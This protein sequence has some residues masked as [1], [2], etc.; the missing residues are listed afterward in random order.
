MTMKLDHVSYALDGSYKSSDQERV[1]D[2]IMPA[3]E[4]AKIPELIADPVAIIQDRQLWQKKAT[5][6]S[7]DVIIAMEINGKKTLVPINVNSKGHINAKE[8]DSNRVQ[9]VHGN[10][11]TLQRLI[12]AL[13]E[14]S[15]DNIAVFYI[16]KEKAT[17]FL[18]PTGNLISSS[19]QTLD[20]FIHSVT[21]KG[22][23]VKMRISSVTES[24]QFMRWFG[25]WKKRPN[26]ASKIVNADGTPKIMCHGTKAENGE[27]Y[28]FDESKE[29][30]TWTKGTGKRQLLY[31]NQARGHR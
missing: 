3:P 5:E 18:W 11:D 16:N 13:N 19:A 1:K 30:R 8:I 9:T 28:I 10:Q 14:D 22:S 15:E 26:E 31:F 23:H 7:V 20:G 12:N 21:D 27:V 29:R 4:L 6:Y 25:N 2:H 17:D 24:Q